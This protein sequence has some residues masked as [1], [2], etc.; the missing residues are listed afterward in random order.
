M[1]LARYRHDRRR[2]RTLVLLLL[3]FSIATLVS[4]CS[5]NQ[6]S[7]NTQ[8]SIDPYALGQELLSV[9]IVLDKP[10]SAILFDEL[11]AAAGITPRTDESK[12]R[13]A[14]FTI[15]GTSLVVELNSAEQPY[16]VERAYPVVTIG[17]PSKSVR[18]ER[19][20]VEVKATA[21][22]PGTPTVATAR[23]IATAGFR[24]ACVRKAGA[25]TIE[26]CIVSSGGRTYVLEPETTGKRYVVSL[27]SSIPSSQLDAAK[28]EAHDIARAAGAQQITFEVAR[29][30]K[31]KLTWAQPA[32]SV[33]TLSRDDLRKALEWLLSHKVLAGITREDIT[34][35]V[36]T[37]EPGGSWWLT[38]LRWQKDTTWDYASGR[39]PPPAGP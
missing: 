8:V 5:K 10:T 25:R 27:L 21:T 32:G 9:Q 7:A 34:S 12:A 16:F 11:P 35:I 2:T 20:V 3:V 36:E 14:S 13:K 29:A 23:A 15:P 37:Y 31:L 4:A 28:R 24:V 6:E 18:E 39:I 26:A 19:S 17:I 1:I 38:P 22:L 33:T 30:R